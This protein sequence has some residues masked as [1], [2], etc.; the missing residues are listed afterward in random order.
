MCMQTW[1]ATATTSESLR[2]RLVLKGRYSHWW[3]RSRGWEKSSRDRQSSVEGIEE[4][5][6]HK[7]P[8]LASGSPHISLN[9]CR[10]VIDWLTWEC[11]WSLPSSWEGGA[12]LAEEGSAN[13]PTFSEA[14]H[15]F[16]TFLQVRERRAKEE[17]VLG[18]LCCCF[19]MSMLIVTQRID[20]TI[21]KMVRLRLRSRC[22]VLTEELLS[23][24]VTADFFPLLLFIWPIWFA[25]CFLTVI[26]VV[27]LHVLAEL[28][29]FFSVLFNDSLQ[30]IFKCLLARLILMKISIM[31]CFLTEHLACHKQTW[32][33][34]RVGPLDCVWIAWVQ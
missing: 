25:C 9:P 13:P 32:V 29:P 18:S 14:S 30:R 28:L 3:E 6:E 17:S 15:S 33:V 8:V 27:C 19:S 22:S 23:W 5:P 16:R 24:T 7:E 31:V 20:T 2:R 11:A 21:S 10:C 4:Q 26:R 1:T 12:G 34:F